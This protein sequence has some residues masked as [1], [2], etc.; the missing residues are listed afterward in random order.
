MVAGVVNS[1]LLKFL[2]NIYWI[3][4]AAILNENWKY[5]VNAVIFSCHVVSSSI[6]NRIILTNEGISFSD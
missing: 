2:G 1:S 6:M 5:K 3:V 4:L